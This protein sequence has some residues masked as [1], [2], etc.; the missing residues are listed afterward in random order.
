MGGIEERE[1]LEM[2]ARMC[3]CVCVKSERLF[4]TDSNGIEK[5]GTPE[6]LICATNK[7]LFKKKGF[8]FQT[9]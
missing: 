4:F 1:A 7:L 2:C 3:V 8:F 9:K 5:Y 6:L